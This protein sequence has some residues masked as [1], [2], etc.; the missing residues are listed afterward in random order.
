M[1]KKQKVNLINEAL[2]RVNAD[3]NYG[4]KAELLSDNTIQYSK[5]FHSAAGRPY[6][7]R[8]GFR[9]VLNQ[10][11]GEDMRRLVKL[12]GNQK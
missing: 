7:G 1:D 10:M 8:V 5:T 9:G 2:K 3:A 6:Q 11:H 12:F 4:C